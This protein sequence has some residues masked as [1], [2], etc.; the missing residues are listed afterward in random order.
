MNILVTGASGFI[1]SQIVT[2]LIKAGHQVTCCVRNKSYASN[3]FPSATII[4]CDFVKDTS[5]EVWISRL[6]DIDVVINAVGIFYHPNKKVIWAIHYDTPKAL[7]DACVSVGVKKIIHISALGIDNVSVDYAESKKAA[8]EY[9]ITLP[10]KSVILRPSLVYG[11]GSY[12]GT[13][14]FRGLTGLPW[15]IPV[16]GKDSKRFNPFIY[17]IYLKL[18]YI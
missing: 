7:F 1:A 3:L 9:L 6:K 8:D 10:I 11:R 12:G 5:K 2:D 13:S 14:L 16:P 15:V 18:L 17:K 4:S